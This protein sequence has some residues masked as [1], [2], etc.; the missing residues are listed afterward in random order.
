MLVVAL[1]PWAGNSK[2]INRVHLDMSEAL[3]GLNS[4][5]V[6]N[7]QYV[8]EWLDSIIYTFQISLQTPIQFPSLY[9]AV[10][11]AVPAFSLLS[12]WGQCTSSY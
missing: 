5:S 9:S 3:L 10:T 6:Y 2:Y 12:V 11:V 4:V 8:A 1:K 7:Y